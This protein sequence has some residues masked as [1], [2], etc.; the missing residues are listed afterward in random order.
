[1]SLPGHED[2]THYY[3]QELAYLR[4][5]GAD[6]A[7]RYPKVASRLALHGAESHDPH[8]ERLI[9]SVA[10]LAARVHR[11]L[12]QT[13]PGVAQGVLDN[14]CP[15]LVQPVPSMTVAQFVLDPAQ[16]KVTAGFEVPKGT[17]LYG[18]TTQAQECRFRTAWSN[19]L[20]PLQIVGASLDSDAVLRIALE[21]NAEVDF[22]ELEIDQLCVHLQGDLTTS[23]A[24]Y[25]ALVSDVL[26]VAVQP[27]DP[28]GQLQT[29]QALPSGAWR[30]LGFDAEHTVLP[31][32]DHAQQAFGLLQEYF[33]FPRKFHF[34][35]LS[36]LRGKLGTGRRCELV[37]QLGRPV[38]ALRTLN[39]QNFALGCVPIINLFNKISEPVL[40]DQQHY[41]YL[42]VADRQRDSYTQV[43]SVTRVVA[44]DPSQDKP[45]QLPH[46]GALDGGAYEEGTVFW[47]LRRQESLRP[48]IAGTDV[49]LSLVDRHSV[50][51]TPGAAVVYAHVLCTNRRLAEQV[52]VGARLMAEGPAQPTRVRCLYE[53][54]AEKDPPVGSKA[55]WHLNSLLSLNHMSLLH[56][57]KGLARLRELLALFASDSR[58]DH[59]QIQGIAALSAG[60]VTTHIGRD[61]WRGFCRGTHINLEF[62]E[63]AYV[64]GSS[65]LMSG[66]LAHFFAMYT[67][68][69]SF[70]R[71]AA[72]RGGEVRKQWAPM[73][74]HQLVL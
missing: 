2:L 65:L 22:S 19:T 12:E 43:H 30:E 21:C 55:L 23:M 7:R 11:D 5:Q 38:Q 15:S 70:V 31:A 59:A 26:S 14:L 64:G 33:A 17:M 54:T 6:F 44:T 25:D 56:S 18:K 3:K 16:G 8:T 10:F 57:E 48:E 69:N 24:L 42:L 46:F 40:I 28:A 51:R 45:V 72:V 41:E 37:L 4:S 58:R 32:P 66:V 36:G 20:W 74:G 1:M 63:E 52:P 29:L 67:A 73:S 71:V 62:D 35:S 50:R 34:F 60:G 53:P 9:E 61:A 13:Q 47:S 39:A 68:M 27:T 49:F